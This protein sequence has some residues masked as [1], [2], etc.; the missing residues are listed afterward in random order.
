[1]KEKAST[2]QAHTVPDHFYF[3]KET[4][5]QPLGSRR[6]PFAGVP[7]ADERK[8]SN[9]TSCLPRRVVEP[10]AAYDFP[11]TEGLS[12][13]ESVMKSLP[14]GPED[15]PLPLGTSYIPGL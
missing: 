8:G 12:E 10:Q 3:P 15:N 1:M 4:P 2:H 9:V 5:L 7:N 14:P 11:G 6:S 13:I